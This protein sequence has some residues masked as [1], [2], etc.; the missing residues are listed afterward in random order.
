M[1]AAHDRVEVPDPPVIDDGDRVQVR[2]VE[3]VVPARETVEV[4]PL[5]DVTV[6]VEVPAVPAAKETVIG[7]AVTLKS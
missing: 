3:F 2:L 5:R 7:F 6:M 4:N 1:L